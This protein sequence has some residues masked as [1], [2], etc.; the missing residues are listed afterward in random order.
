MSR[1][2]FV[3]VVHGGAGRPPKLSGWH[4]EAEAGM[5]EAAQ[6]GERILAARGTAAEAVVAAVRELESCPAF[7]AGLGSVANTEG[8]VEMDAALMEGVELRAGA[9]AGLRAIRHPIEAARA[10]LEAGVHLLYAGEGAECFAREAGLE[11][12]EPAVLAAAAPEWKAASSQGTVGAVALDNAGHL[13]A[14]TSTGG[15]PGKRPGRIS[16]SAIIGA[17]TWA[18][19][20]SCA[21]STTGHGESFMRCVFAHAVAERCRGGLALPEACAQMLTRVEELGGKGG[22]IAVDRQGNVAYPYDTRIM[23]RAVVREGA[24]PEITIG[25]S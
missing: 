12:I 2:G 1:P 4:A 19:D 10:V 7:N 13:A 21:V 20:A 25:T 15:T 11:G 23:P 8:M 22:C 16:D 18:D 3:L 24:A 5:R 14:A 6:A 17:G 9:V